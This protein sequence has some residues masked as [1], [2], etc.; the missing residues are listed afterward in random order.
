MSSR[1]P[2]P[3]PTAEADSQPLETFTSTSTTTP[4]NI[5]GSQALSPARIKFLQS[6]IK[7]IRRSKDAQ[8]FNR[9]VDIV[10]LNIPHY[11]NI[12]K[13][14]MDLGQ[15][16]RKLNA[17]Q[18]TD[19]GAVVA[20][21]QLVWTNSYAFNGRDHLVSQAAARLEEAFA[22]MLRNLPPADS[23]HRIHSRQKLSLTLSS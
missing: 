14:P 7:S 23:V 5:P 22:R 21:V 10:V 6:S 13:T 3:T 9:P 2:I 16:E 1:Q 11:P 17:N 8:A 4:I 18:Y 19:V 20:D 12:V 15:V